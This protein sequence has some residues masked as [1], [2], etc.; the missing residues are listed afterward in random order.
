MRVAVITPFYNTPLHWLEQCHASV[1]AQ[2][3][4]CT[5][6]LV[7]D[8][9]GENPLSDFEGEYIRLPKPHADNGNTPRAVGST[10]AAGEGFDAIA[11]LDAD[12]WYAANHIESLV[13]LK[14]QTG[15]AVCTSGRTLHNLSGEL[16]GP[17]VEVDGKHFVDTSCLFITRPAY[18]LTLQWVFMPREFS[19]VC[20]F[21]VWS[22]VRRSLHP[23]AHTGLQTM[24]FRTTYPHHFLRFGLPPPPGAKSLE[25]SQDCA[26][27][28]HALRAVFGK[29]AASLAP[30]RQR[31]S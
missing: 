7:S 14:Q 2:T 4:P 26:R 11:Y 24:A 29:N 20:D 16:L 31:Q 17:C 8:G 25:Y 12:N 9:A 27:R 5:H 15:A 3:H 23:T 6:F 21:W 10:T 13:T 19:V 28:I 18:G 30:Q 1:R 22:C